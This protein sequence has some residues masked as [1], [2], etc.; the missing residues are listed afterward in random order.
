M[1][2]E[3]PFGLS[4]KKHPFNEYIGQYVDLYTSRPSS[5][6]GKVKEINQE[7]YV[8]LQPFIAI[9]YKPSG[10]VR[11]LINKPLMIRVTDII[12]L[13]PLTEEGVVNYCNYDTIK[14]LVSSHIKFNEVYTDGAGI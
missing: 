10:P 1:N 9:D 2:R 3:I 11:K 5:F 6:S 13:E 12:A 7:G 14:N 4:K 8:L